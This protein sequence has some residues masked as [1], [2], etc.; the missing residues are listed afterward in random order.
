MKGRVGGK[1]KWIVRI[2]PSGHDPPVSDIKE[3][4]KK[5][6]EYPLYTDI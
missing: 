1:F 4:E 3:D 2:E 5:K 6:K